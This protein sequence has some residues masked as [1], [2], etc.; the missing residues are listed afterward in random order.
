M[1]QE[2]KSKIMLI[3]AMSIWGTIGIFRRYIPLPSGMIAFTRGLIGTIFLLLVI[4]IGRKKISF[5]A[6]K[7][8]LVLLILSGALMAVNW[9]LLFE[10]YKY[11]TVATATVCYYMEPVFVMMVSPIFLKEKLSVKKVIC[12]LASL[13]GMVFVSGLFKMKGFNTGDFKG[14]LLGLGAAALYASV[15]ILNKK[16]KDIGPYDKTVMQLGTSIFVILPYMLL[17]ED[18]TVVFE[19]IGIIMMLLVGILHTGVAYTLYFGS[20]DNVKAQTIAL[21]SYIDP[22][23]AI[24]LSALILHEKIGVMEILGAAM[25]LGA[26]LIS[27]L[28]I[29]E[30]DTN[31]P[32]MNN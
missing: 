15:V 21:F 25:V 1:K 19:P 22:V 20:M 26:T 31:K 29:F 28:P 17:V 14:V 23:V 6:I 30:K 11:T 16:M 27:E 32:E 2:N 10:A 13:G 24:I 5:K 7:D 3:L 4:L 8:N 12:I 9:I 18:I